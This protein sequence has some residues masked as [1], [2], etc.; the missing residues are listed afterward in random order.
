MYFPTGA[1]LSE[2]KNNLPSLIQNYGSAQSILDEKLAYYLL[3]RPKH[4]LALN[5]ASQAF[6]WLRTFFAAKRPLIP[7]PTFGEYARIFPQA[8]CYPDDVGLDMEKIA[9]QARQHDLLVLVNPNNPTGSTLDTAWIY[10]YAAGNLE[11]TVIVDESFV[12]F[13]GQK[14]LLPMLEAEPL[15]NVILVKSLSKALGAPGLR[16]GYVY[17]AHP[18]FGAF[19]R[20]QVP[21]WNLNSL[22]EQFLEI[23][24]KHRPVIQASF[25]HT[26]LDRERFAADLKA[27]P[28]VRQVHQSGGNFLLVSLRCPRESSGT[29]AGE[30]LRRHNIHIKDVSDRFRSSGA[31]FRLAVRLPQENAQLVRCLAQLDTT[32][33]PA[34]S[35][36]D[37]RSPELAP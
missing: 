27:L 2:I 16:L 32:P 4:L 28:I 1:I 3:C 13:S 15:P 24:L 6:P 19:A 18:G 35:A 34:T 21:I 9:R 8:A 17:T 14:S 11:K 29:L 25:A 33:A 23:I 12:E 31:S 26:I 36:S 10:N 22:A 20:A 5:G 30:L 37:N 7:A